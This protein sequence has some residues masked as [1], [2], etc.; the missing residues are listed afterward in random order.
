MTLLDP[1]EFALPDLPGSRSAPRHPDTKE[2]AHREGATPV[3]DVNATVAGDHRPPATAAIGEAQL[4][5]QAVTL[6]VKAAGAALLP[7]WFA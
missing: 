3:S 1:Y 4:A 7:V 6:S 2:R 5:V